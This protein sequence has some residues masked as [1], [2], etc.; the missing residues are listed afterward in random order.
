[1]SAG[2]NDATS[3]G[4]EAAVR[5][6]TKSLGADAEVFSQESA[7]VPGTDRRLVRVTAAA[8]GKPNTTAQVVVDDDGTVVDLGA[9]EA[10]VGQRIFVPDIGEIP[11]ATI[12]PGRVTISPISN[13]FS[14][15]CCQEWAETIKVGIPRSGA[16]PKAD[17]YL[18]AD[19]T[20]SMY[21]VIE[22]V[23]AGIPGIVASFGAG[24]DVAFGVGNYKDFPSDPYR[25][26][27]QLSPTTNAPQVNSAVATWSASGGADGAEGQFF[28]LH[29]LA[30]DP[31]INWRPGARRIIV[32]FG[33][34]P[35]HDPICMAINSEVDIT[36]ASVTGELV[37]AGAT[38]VAISV[39]TG[40]PGGLD[41]DPVAVLRRLH[42]CLRR[43][44]RQPRA[45]H[46]DHRGHRRVAHDGDQRRHD[47]RDAH[48][49]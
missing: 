29:K 10:S 28:A 4:L 16:I 7:I 40:V 45:G 18:L 25:F 48:E 14:L 46:P 23:K 12:R 31:A 2:S 15:E 27:H 6:L 3:K 26:Q 11:A 19:T 39:T 22:A 36:E 24:F 17:V 34:Y 33:D 35:G 30:V 21:S 9:L 47:R 42:G 5:S 32:W 8:A 38:V 1:M 49:S 13:D 43:P 37:T 41:A 44:R 20:G